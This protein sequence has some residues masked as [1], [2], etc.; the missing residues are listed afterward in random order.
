[1]NSVRSWNLVV[2][3]LVAATIAVSGV[4][5]CSVDSKSKPVALPSKSVSAQVSA[6]EANPTEPAQTVTA[7][8]TVV[9]PESLTTNLVD[10]S[11]GG[12]Q[13]KSSFQLKKSFLACVGAQSESDT[14]VADGE[15]PSILNVSSEMIAPVTNNEA[16]DNASDNSTSKAKGRFGFLIVESAE[17]VVGKSILELEKSFIDVAGTASGVS[18]STLED[19]LYLNSLQTIA[20]VI[21]FNCDVESESSQCYCATKPK[22]KEMVERCLTL[23]D[24]STDEFKAAL[25]GFTEACG[26]EATDDGLFKRRKAIVSLL[27]SYAFA[28]SR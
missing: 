6:G 12:R 9:G 2:I 24:P 23:F 28:T 14:E 13:R 7:Q 17:D 19:E 11:A 8:P 25:D 27:S 20:S 26:T 16:G 3:N 22:A 4:A 18:A 15:N 1:M 21:A 10:L 5:A